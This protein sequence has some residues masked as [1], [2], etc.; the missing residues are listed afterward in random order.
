MK[1]ILIGTLA[2]AAGFIGLAAPAS[3]TNDH[4]VYVCHWANGNPHVIRIDDSG[5]NGH[6]EED[7]SPKQVPGHLL[8]V[9]LGSSLSDEEED[10]CENQD[11]P[12]NP[13]PEGPQGPK[14]DPGENGE[15]GENGLTPMIL[16]FPGEGFGFTLDR[17]Y[18]GNGIV[19]GDG[20]ICPL[21]GVDGIKGLDGKDGI[22]GLNGTNGLD[23]QNGQKGLDGAAGPVGPA[24]TNVV[25]ESN[26]T[27]TTIAAA[28]VAPLDELP[29]TGSSLV[30][31]ALF[32]ALVGFVGLVL[33]FA[34]RH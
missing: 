21:A 12:E 27:P 32:G 29:R 28:P 20:E 24:G 1:K 13:G 33:R 19:L 4:K 30:Y 31:L 7:G 23:G 26:T 25:V 10:A 14:G 15:N 22:N 2:V 17:E 6:F 3:A 16:C 18:E 5:L 8:D 11:L 34:F 9:N